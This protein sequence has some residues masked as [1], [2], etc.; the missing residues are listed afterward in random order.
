M[1]DILFDAVLKQVEILFSK[2]KHESID[3]IR[4]GYRY[5]DERR[6]HSQCGT[7]ILRS[8]LRRWLG[9]SLSQKQQAAENGAAKA[10]SVRLHGLR[11][12]LTQV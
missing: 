3:R 1:R 2:S 4:H 7:S 12:A 9:G 6:L 5:L 8:V 11:P 10:E